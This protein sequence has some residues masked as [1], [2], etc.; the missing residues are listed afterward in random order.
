MKAWMKAKENGM[1]ESKEKKEEIERKRTRYYRYSN[2]H[3]RVL[4]PALARSAVWMLL[5][6]ARPV[7]IGKQP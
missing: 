6:G 1:E 2:T 7:P 5:A 3:S 4:L